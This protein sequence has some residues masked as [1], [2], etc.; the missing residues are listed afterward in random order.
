[1]TRKKHSRSRSGWSIA[2]DGRG[3]DVWGI[4]LVLVGLVAALGTYADAAG[5]LGEG[6][7]DLF[8]W[9][10]G[11]LRVFVPV[12]AV[13]L[14]YRLMR[15]PGEH[16]RGETPGTV[17]G[18]LLAVGALAGF[19]HLF[20]GRPTVDQGA[21]ALGDAGGVLGLVIGGPLRSVASIYGAV[22]ILGAVALTGGVLFTGIPMSSVLDWL[23][24]VLGPAR[25][26]AVR[27]MQNLFR[28][29]D[30]AREQAAPRTRKAR[31]VL[32]DTDVFDD[33]DADFAAF[34]STGEFE[35]IEV[36]VPENEAYEYEEDEDE[37]A[38]AEYEEDED[39]DAEYEEDEDADYEEDGEYDEEGEY[40]DDEGDDDEAEDEA[41]R[42]APK[43]VWK[44]PP[45]S[46]L[47][48]SGGR[49]ID[50]AAV[51]D[52]GR[53]L[54]RALAEHGVQTRLVGMVVG[55]TVTRYELELGPGVKVARVTS[56]H[57]DI[58][59]AMAS[60]DV[61][62]LAP[63]PGRQ[64]I[65]VEVPNEQREVVAVGDIL[66][67][68]EARNATHPLEVAIGRDING[69]AILANLAT[70][71]H[72]LIAGATGAGKSSCINSLITSVLMRSTPDDVRMILVDPKMVEM[73]QYERVPHLLTAVVTDPKKAANALGWAVR[74]MERRYE[75][76]KK[77]GFR[78]ITGYNAA[79]D[80]GEVQ[81]GLGEI[82][83]DG[84]PL[85]YQRLSFILVVVDELADLMM[86]A[87]RDVEDS[88]IRIAQKA[89]AVGIHLV[90]ATQ[91]P[92]VNV[93]TGLI[94]ANVPAR[95][96][97]AVSSQTDSRVILDQPGAERLVGKGDMLLVTPAS[98]TPNRIQGSWVSEDEVR[99]VVAAWR[100]QQP[101]VVYEQSVAVETQGRGE[102]M[103]IDLR[104]EVVAAPPP[105]DDDGDELLWQAM[106]LVVSS[107]LGSTSMLQRKLR[108]GFSRAGRLMDLLE[109]R[110][111]VGPS[112]GS[113][114]RTVLMTPEDLE[115]LKHNR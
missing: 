101:D 68:A 66:A 79:F 11:L 81:A 18:A 104:D 87:A 93:I 90:I 106:E 27:G 19:S 5:A 59:Y 44:L 112:E 29:D 39:E 86:V 24:R 43:I 98:S 80:R 42:R 17:L 100:R 1:V 26:G 55:P 48:R 34:E 56:L 37:D 3:H 84:E 108:V 107:Q 111:V 28:V 36:E 103:V 58:A 65:G 99:A 76:L 113:K 97:F 89:R 71:P 31:G 74:E 82:D 64:A 60:P 102:Q 91:R 16:D 33:G 52:R 53:L 2:F 92:S 22:L 94:K 23:G 51:R 54:E 78:D 88:I 10:V 7:D 95:L 63:I 47:K 114:A 40:E 109:Q 30:E 70:M 20:G 41:P 45:M 15:G 57:R 115:D 21:D 32:E 8:G 62:I 6:V 14:G 105:D 61:R 77:C 75:L 25:D 69:K 73:G 4:I 49:E 50:R 9:A 35:E 110:G 83:D 12:A 38:E 67:S 72:L 46:L 85:E 96:A 13:F